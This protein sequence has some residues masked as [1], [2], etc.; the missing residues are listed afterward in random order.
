M[1]FYVKYNFLCYTGQ[2]K[3]INSKGESTMK[4]SSLL[5]LTAVALVAC[6]ENK[7]TPADYTTVESEITKVTNLSIL[8]LGVGGDYIVALPESDALTE[9]ASKAKTVKFLSVADPQN[10][11]TE[12][13][14][15]LNIIPANT[16][17]AMNTPENTC[18]FRLFCGTADDIT[19]NEFYAVEL[20]S[21]AE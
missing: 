3:T 2:C 17:A 9:I 7:P 21:S 19:N 12:G 6:G 1:I 16:M 4:K 11:L 20:C 8:A 15:L 5:A 18:N 14:C 10:Y 13:N